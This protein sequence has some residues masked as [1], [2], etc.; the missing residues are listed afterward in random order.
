MD[1]HH[2]LSLFYTMLMVTKGMPAFTF[3]SIFN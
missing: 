2:W 1:R 3:I